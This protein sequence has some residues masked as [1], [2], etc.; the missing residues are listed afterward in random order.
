M[1]RDCD[2]VTRGQYRVVPER[3]IGYLLN[4]PRVSRAYT[5][6]LTLKDTSSRMEDIWK[7]R[8]M[9]LFLARCNILHNYGN[10]S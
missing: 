8:C 1:D 3:L 2:T 5:N 7:P 4:N 6:I 10:L 9:G